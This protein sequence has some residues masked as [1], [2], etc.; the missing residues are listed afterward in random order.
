MRRLRTPLSDA[1]VGSLRVGDRV[2][3]SGVLLAA[4]DAAHLR[5]A[6]ALAGG[7]R[8]PV[9]LEGQV[10]Y[11]VGPSPARPGEVIGSAGPTTASRMDRFTPALLAL[12]LKATIGKGGR[13][14]EVVEAMRRHRA[15]YFGA[16]GGTG[17][18][19]SRRIRAAEVVAYEDLGPEA[20]RRLVVE[21]FPVI[22]VNDVEGRDLFQEEKAR[23]RRLPD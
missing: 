8:L 12:G 4:R 17:A 6:D 9:D 3:L 1:D 10:L 21:D 22:V 23:Y 11:Y 2:L 7:E 19:L 18:L 16:V 5:F 15:V 20:V 14:P 13:S